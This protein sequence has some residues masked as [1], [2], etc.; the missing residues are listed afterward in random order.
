MVR[1]FVVD[2]ETD[3]IDAT[4]IHCMSIHDGDSITTLTNYADMQIF[5]GQLNNEDKVIG[6]NFLRY[7]LP[8]CERI[9]N[10]KIPCQVID[11]LALSWYLF[12][13]QGKYAGLAYNK[14]GLADWGERFG[15]AKPKVEDWENAEL[16]TYIH[17]CEEDVKI[18]FKLWSIQKSYLNDLYQDKPERLIKYLM[19][20]MSCAA[21]QEDCKWKLDVEKANSFLDKLYKEYNEL[22]DVLKANMPKVPK[23]AKRKRPAKPF[24]QDGSLSAA[25]M[26]W[27]ELCDLNDIDFDSNEE[28]E[29]IVKLEEPNPGSVSQ[30]K[31][32]LFSL[33]WEPKFYD[34]RRDSASMEDGVPQ[35][36]DT[37][38]EL[39]ESVKRLSKEHPAVS[40]LEKIT[41]IKHR[42]GTVEGYLKNMTPSGFLRA[43]VGNF[44]NTLRFA[45][46]I[47]VN[48]PSERKLYG[49]EVRELLTVAD[50]DQNTLCGSD[51]SSL[52]DRTKQ[53]FMWRYD[54]EFVKEMMTPDFD[55][56]LD[57][58]L[59]A[60]ALTQEQV[61]C[62]KN[63]EKTEEITQIRHNYKGGNYACTYGAGAK[64]LATQL[65]VTEREAAKIHKAYWKRNWS[66]RKIREDARTK[67]CRDSLWLYNPVSKLW[68]S[69]RAEKDIFSTLNQG[70][71][72]FC[73]DMWLGFILKERKQLT[74]QFHD[75][76]ILECKESEKQ[77]IEQILHTSLEKVNKALNLHRDLDCDIQFGKNYSLIH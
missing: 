63:G 72:T 5:F 28:I 69:L 35:I 2:I 37:S 45:H 33:G 59:S 11:S 18:N 23:T 58:A 77:V 32:W 65:G 29:V 66:L 64:T 10:V 30:V 15:I 7:D 76:L 57:L 51:L 49:L 25:G 61:D 60:G 21:L 24:K 73:F 1:E 50:N 48:I 13:N 47:C 22:A 41:T 6:H 42:I 9:L 44:T 54:P 14:H 55:P 40:A 16:C 38:G 70:T 27:K 3:G 62:Y 19:F 52:E 53:H 39:C 17:R 8:I 34:H 68:Y 36:K 43:S 67:K 31:D 46:R 56:H 12:P 4:K 71:G 74:A 26:K 75:E 20:K